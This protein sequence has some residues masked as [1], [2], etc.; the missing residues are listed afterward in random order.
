MNR[1]G[2]VA[3]AG[4][5]SLQQ[6]RTTNVGVPHSTWKSISG[7]STIPFALASAPSLKKANTALATSS[8]GAGRERHPRPEIPEVQEA[9]RAIWVATSGPD[10]CPAP[11]P[12]RPAA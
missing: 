1:S 5:K 2:A 7:L 12:A 6:V 9:A 10:R 11:R 4:S 8:V 3:V